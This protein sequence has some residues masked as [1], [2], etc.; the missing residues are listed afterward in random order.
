[1]LLLAVALLLIIGKEALLV[2]RGN[3][4]VPVAAVDGG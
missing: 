3:D 2:L 1:M 4:E